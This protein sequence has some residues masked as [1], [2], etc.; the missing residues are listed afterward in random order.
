[1]LLRIVLALA[2][3]PSKSFRFEELPPLFGERVAAIVKELTFWAEA[4][5]TKVE[6][7]NR[8]ACVSVPALVI[9]L[10]DQYCNAKD[11]MLTK[12]KYAGKYLGKAGILVETT[13]SKS[14]AIDGRYGNGRAAR[15]IA[16][17][18]GLANAVTCGGAAGGPER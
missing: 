11:F 9:K 6:Y 10:A 13:R 4:V 18:D 2:P 14:D 1:L 17:Y 16:D 15:T 12:P 7:L 3:T 5:V 8:F